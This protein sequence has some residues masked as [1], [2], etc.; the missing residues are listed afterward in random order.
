MKTDIFISAIENRFPVRFLYRLSE[1]VL[2]P[3]FVTFNGTGKKVIY[4]RVNNTNEIK[5]FEYE[6]ITNIKTLQYNRFSPII[7]LVPNYN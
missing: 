1:I 7:P 3:Y 5:V 6:K 2:E 4:G